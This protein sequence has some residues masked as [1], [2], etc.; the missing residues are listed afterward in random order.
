MR[1]FVARM[2]QHALRLAGCLYL[3]EYPVNYEY[4]IPAPLMQT[5]LHMTEV[6]LSHVLR[7][8]IKD[9]GDVHVECCRAIMQFILEKNFSNVSETVLKQALRHRFKAADVSIA[10]YY[11]VSQKYLYEGLSEFTGTGKRGRPAGQTLFNPYYDPT[12]CSF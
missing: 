8:T 9:Y 2:P 1:E 5:A 4:P 12:G 6:F 7:W 11:L 3:A 10:I